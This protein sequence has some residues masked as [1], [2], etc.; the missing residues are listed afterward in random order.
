MMDL[1]KFRTWVD[2]AV[3]YLGLLN[4]A[5]ILYLYVS[6]APMGI[7]WYYWVI[8]A[9]GVVSV[10]IFI[11]IK[12]IYPKAQSYVAELNPA[13]VKLQATMDRI[14]QKLDAR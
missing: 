2:R 6:K 12:F 4:F 9:I 8:A 3:G 7:E 10:I 11:D 1:G 13:W 14:E 5:M